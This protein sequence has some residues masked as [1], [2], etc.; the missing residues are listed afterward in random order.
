MVSSPSTTQLG[1]TRRVFRMSRRSLSLTMLLFLLTSSSLPG[2]W[3]WRNE[4]TPR[5]VLSG[6][7]SERSVS[8]QRSNGEMRLPVTLAAGQQGGI[9]LSLDQQSPP[10]CFPSPSRS[11]NRALQQG[12]ICPAT[13]RLTL[14]L[15]GRLNSQA[16]GPTNY[17]VVLS[18]PDGIE[19][20]RIHVLEDVASPPPQSSSLDC[21]LSSP[22]GRRQQQ[23]Q[24][25]LGPRSENDA[26]ACR[27]TRE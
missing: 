5:S 19:I 26:P 4:M 12:L 17:E 18:D 1:S 16:S 20:I 2:G 23:F 24:R 15:N 13:D 22:L 10:T 14:V 27:I 8:R 11:S 9:P 3:L 7:F 6:R 21:G 25:T